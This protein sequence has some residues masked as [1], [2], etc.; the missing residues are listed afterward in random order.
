MNK[1]VFLVIL[2]F[3]AIPVTLLSQ[4]HDRHE[5]EFGHVHKKNEISAALGIVPLKHEHE[6]TAGLHL[7]YIR[8]V[9][10]HNKLGIGVGF[11]TI[12]D[13]HKHFTISV[14]FQYRIYKGWSVAYAPGLLMVKENE[15]Y[16][17][18]FAQHFET[19]YEWEIGK[20]HIGPMAEVGV[21]PNGVHYMLGVHFGIDF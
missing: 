6:V 17:Y 12:F 21:E 15:T 16:E 14:V 2:L 10:F 18:Q 13:E 3:V 9:A 19:A 7:H 8:G 20:F 11:E 4:N 1:L 5:E